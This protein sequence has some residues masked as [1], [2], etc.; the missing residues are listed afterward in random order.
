MNKN[1]RN[2]FDIPEDIA[3]FNVAGNSPQ[4]KKSTEALINGVVEKANPW[5]KKPS[6]FF[7]LAEKIRVLASKTFG[8]KSQ[9]YAIVPSAS[10]GISTAARIIEKTIKPNE[11]IILMEEE[12][13]SNVLPWRRVSKETGAK[14][15]TIQRPKDNNWT[16]AILAG[17]TNETKVTAISPCHWTDGTIVDLH[18]IKLKC[19]QINSLLVLDA[20]QMLGASPIDIEKIDPDFLVAAGY[21]WLLSPYGFSLMY[22]SKRMR[23]ERPLEESWL[24]RENSEDFANLINYNDNYLPGARRYDMGEK[25][26]ATILPAVITAFEQ[27]NEWGI[28]NISNHL[29]AINGQIIQ[30]FEQ[31]GFMVPA[32]KYLSTHMFGVY[33]EE[34]RISGIIK[35]LTENNVFISRRG[36]ALRI[37]PHLHI[38]ERD[39]ETFIRCLDRI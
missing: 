38:T 14:I 1:Y 12:F 25:N 39:I 33:T 31:K 13:P 19:E 7:D 15:K 26:T 27:I 10:Y 30:K 9:G 35:N 20:T 29:K 2:L 34:D 8:G 32:R 36:N 24:A 17:I 6:Q 28:K 4:L 16:R 37:S 3:Y 23:G 11:N 22:V 5:N 21:K 18:K